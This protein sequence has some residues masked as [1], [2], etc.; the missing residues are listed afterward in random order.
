MFTEL[1]LIL[2]LFTLYL[3]ILAGFYW[4]FGLIILFKYGYCFAGLFLLILPAII[5]SKYEIA[6]NN[7]S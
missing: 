1:G 2:A 6:L 4:A 5:G 7:T 3:F